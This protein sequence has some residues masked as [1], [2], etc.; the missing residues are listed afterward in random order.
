M[1][2]AAEPDALGAEPARHLARRAG[3]RRWCAPSAGGTRRPSRAWSRTA[4]SGSGVTTG[5]APMTTSP[6]VPLI[7]MTSPSLTTAPFTSN[8]A[9]STSMSS[10]LAPHTAGVPMPRATTAAWLTSPPRDVRMPSAAIMPWRSS[11]DVSGR[12]R[13]TRSP[14]SWCASASSAVKY[15]LP[16]AAPG[17]AFRPLVIAV[18]LRRRGRTAGAAAGRAARARRAAPP[19]AC[20]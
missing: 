6:V 4:R 15:T 9:P 16:T 8:A 3:G 14:A 11:G 1:L 10:S 13:I 20:R 5:T 7:E 19:R 12:T 18:V 2:G 17:D